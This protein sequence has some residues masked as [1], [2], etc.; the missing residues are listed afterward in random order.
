MYKVIQCKIDKLEG[1]INEEIGQGW[2]VAGDIQSVGPWMDAC[3]LMVKVAASAN[4]VVK[5]K[6]KKAPPV[7]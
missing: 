1:R 3:I 5:R 7:E 4:K 2:T 6:P